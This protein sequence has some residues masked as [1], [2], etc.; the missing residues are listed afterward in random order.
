VSGVVEPRVAVPIPLMAKRAAVFAGIVAFGWT[1]GR[2]L[3][4]QPPDWLVER[5]QSLLVSVKQLP[6]T[7]LDTWL[8]LLPPNLR[9]V[10]FLNLEALRALALSDGIPV[11]YVAPPEL[12]GDLLGADSRDERLE[13][14]RTNQQKIVDYC[15][16]VLVDLDS[17]P[18]VAEAQ[19]AVRTFDAGFVASAQSHVANIVD[20]A[21]PRIWGKEPNPQGTWVPRREATRI[22]ETEPS[23]KGLFLHF[24]ESLVA[25]PIPSAYRRHFPGDPVPSGFSRHASAHSLGV[26]GLVSDLNCLVGLML[27]TSLVCYDASPLSERSRRSL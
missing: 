21:L 11:A 19:E 5:A 9:D 10:P 7:L 8:Q 15:R 25:A 23:G 16:T 2:R 24:A 1:A 20:S 26:E 13:L 12:F 3:D 18:L 4:S 14:L 17:S 6:A 22:G 27:A